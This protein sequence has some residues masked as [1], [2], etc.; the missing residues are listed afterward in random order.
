MGEANI[1]EEESKGVEMTYKCNA[2]MESVRF[3]FEGEVWGT[4]SCS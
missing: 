3:L 1:Q 4:R 2:V